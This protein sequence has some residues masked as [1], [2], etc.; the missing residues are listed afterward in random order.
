[1]FQIGHDKWISNAEFN[2]LK[3]DDLVQ[4]TVME[5]RVIDQDM[6]WL[7]V[8]FPWNHCC[9]MSGCIKRAQQRMPDVQAISTINQEG[10]DTFYYKGRFSNAQPQDPD[11]WFASRRGPKPAGFEDA[12][13]SDEPGQ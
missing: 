11:K 5:W 9:S 13:Y 12:P 10:I 8:M 7:A 4:C 1:M 6:K 3:R 2:K